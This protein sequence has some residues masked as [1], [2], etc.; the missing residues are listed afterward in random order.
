MS[1][2]F[3]LTMKAK[4]YYYYS[5]NIGYLGLLQ[6]PFRY[7]TTTIISWKLILVCC[8]GSGFPI[9]CFWTSKSH[10]S[11][12]K[13]CL[14]TNTLLHH[15]RFSLSNLNRSIIKYA[16]YIKFNLELSYF[17]PDLNY[18]QIWTFLNS[19]MFHF[20]YLIQSLHISQLF[21]RIEQNFAK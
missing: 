1:R 19:L 4:T 21:I 16:K 8:Y 10:W 5:G 18:Q 2:Q 6:S 12:S 13:L 11:E 3:D 17:T 7:L 20:R 9:K 14:H 15:S